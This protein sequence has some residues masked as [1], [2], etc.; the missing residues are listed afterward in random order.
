MIFLF[1]AIT[2]L[3]SL[4]FFKSYYPYFKDADDLFSII[5]FIMVIF[6]FSCFMAVIVFTP[7][8]IFIE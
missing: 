6:I 1:I 4:L 7:Y 5:G 2:A 3:L 8:F